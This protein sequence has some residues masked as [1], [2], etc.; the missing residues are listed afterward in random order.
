MVWH[1]MPA[2]HAA[3]SENGTN[4]I[5]LIVKSLNQKIGNGVDKLE[6]PLYN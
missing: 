6:H 4:K 2:T 1:T 3:G 5:F